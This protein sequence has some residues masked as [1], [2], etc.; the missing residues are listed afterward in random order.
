M[1]QRKR[2]TC[3]SMN[4]WVSLCKG[5]IHR[6]IPRL[7]CRLRLLKTKPLRKL[8][9]FPRFNIRPRVVP[10]ADCKPLSTKRKLWFQRFPLKFQGKRIRR[11]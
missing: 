2:S 11:M 7:W 4:S 3:V 8:G 1:D 6:F 10:K 5:L 9:M